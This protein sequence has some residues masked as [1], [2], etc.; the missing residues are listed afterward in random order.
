MK[1]IL[2]CR[3]CSYFGDEVKENA[4]KGVFDGEEFAKR[5]WLE[6]KATQVSKKSFV[7]WKE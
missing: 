3:H 5:R 2:N 1:F 7:S 6:T 4:E